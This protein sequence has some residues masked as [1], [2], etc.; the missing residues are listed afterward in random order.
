MV[1]RRELGFGWEPMPLF[2]HQVARRRLAMVSLSW[3]GRIL[4][5]GLR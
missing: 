2:V 4:M 1:A 5:V 3:F